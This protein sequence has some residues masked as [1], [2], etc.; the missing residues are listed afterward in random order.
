MLPPDFTTK[1]HTNCLNQ[2]LKI[3]HP[4]R[5]RDASLVVSRRAHFT[6][7]RHIVNCFLLFVHF[8][9]HRDEQLAADTPEQFLA[10]VLIAKRPSAAALGRFDLGAW[11]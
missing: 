6:A 2:F 1:T 5:H 3:S 10:L 9:F 4:T 7:L 11:R 8:G